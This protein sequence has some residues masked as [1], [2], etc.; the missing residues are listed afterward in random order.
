MKKVFSLLFFVFAISFSINAQS[1]ATPISDTQKIKVF[2]NPASNVVNI[3]GLKNSTKAEIIISDA[4][5]NRVLEHHWG[6]KNNALN[7]PVSSLIS[8][9]YIATIR[10]QEQQVQTK[11]YKK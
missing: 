4:Y 5:G 7:I 10:S 8:G 11:F 2:P 6:I 3:L 1:D 9:I